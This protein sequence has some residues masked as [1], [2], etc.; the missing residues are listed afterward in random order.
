MRNKRRAEARYRLAVSTAIWD[1][2]EAFF[3][4]LLHTDRSRL[5]VQMAEFMLSEARW[6]VEEFMTAVINGEFDQA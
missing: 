1:N 3:R 5:D 4:A 2:Y 6:P